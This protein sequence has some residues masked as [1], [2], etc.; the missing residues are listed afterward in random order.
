[1]RIAT[2]SESKEIDRQAQEKHGLSAEILMESAGCLAA[3]EIRSYWVELM[4]TKRVRRNSKANW[5]AVV[6]G[7]GGNG[8]DGLVAARHLASAGLNVRVYL[9]D[10]TT[11]HDLFKLNLKRLPMSIARRTPDDISELGEASLIVDALLGLGASRN[12]HGVMKLLIDEMNQSIAPC[13]SLD[14]PSG[15]D[16]DRGQCFGVSVLAAMTL[17]FG[18]AKRGFFVNE[19]PRV[20]GRLKI[21][22]IGFPIEVIREVA[23]T[24]SAFGA[25]SARQILPKRKSS[26]NKALNGRTLIFAGRPGMMGAGLLS[27]LGAMRSGSGYVTL[28]THLSENDNETR[29]KIRTAAP[30]FQTLSSEAPDIWSHVKD[31][32]VIVGPGFGVG[33]ETLKILRELKQR[34]VSSVVIDAD[35]LTTLAESKKNHQEWPVLKSW[36]LTP[37]AGELARLVGGT[38]KELEAKR[39]ESVEAAA[40]ELGAIV[41]FKGFRTIISDGS[42]S[43]VILSGNAALSKAGSGD[44]LT[45]M[46]GGFLAQK[47]APF[48]AACLGAYVHGRVADDWLKSGRDV[49]SLL[50]SDIAETLPRILKQLRTDNGFSQ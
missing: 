9:Y 12:I 13:L 37:H 10:S 2:V 19:G 46:I 8:A 16:A 23:Q 18:L 31:A 33:E 43:C 38:A 15:L 24:Q 21:L 4:N 22:P 42:R 30:E 1:M 20:V 45:G 34:K 49:L 14:L 41:L 50:P 11:T 5:I 17:T 3:N 32:A 44:I 26:S 7:P 47:I 27:G 35:G 36:I 48:D 29:A 25:R 28:I 40:K 39:F 6:C